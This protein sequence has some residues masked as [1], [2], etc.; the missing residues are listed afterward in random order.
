MLSHTKQ[1]TVILN[2]KYPST[3]K[4]MLSIILRYAA[5]ESKIEAQMYKN[6]IILFTIASILFEN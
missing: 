6:A 1:Y 5:I 3:L 4:K 2:I